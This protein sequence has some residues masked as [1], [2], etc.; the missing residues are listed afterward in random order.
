MCVMH[1]KFVGGGLDSL[2]KV[3]YE[4]G[5]EDG[6]KRLTP[7]FAISQS[8]IWANPDI[9]VNDAAQR[10][11]AELNSYIL[12]L[13]QQAVEVEREACARVAEIKLVDGPRAIAAAIRARGEGK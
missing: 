3:A 1:N 6:A 10:V 9:P 8:G 7:M 11:L 13:V 2:T 12:N 5:Y 4:A